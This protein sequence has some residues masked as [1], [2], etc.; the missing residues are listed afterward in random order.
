MKISVSNFKPFSDFSLDEITAAG[1]L[2]RVS[3]YIY[4]R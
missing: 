4:T 3:F 2:M 1:N